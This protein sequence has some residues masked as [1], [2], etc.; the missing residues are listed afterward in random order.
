MKRA[1]G[2]QNRGEF[3]EI[4]KNG[5]IPLLVSYGAT[6]PPVP[7]GMTREQHEERW[8]AELK[9]TRP[10][11]YQ[12]DH[13]EDANYEWSARYGAKLAHE[14]QYQDIVHQGPEKGETVEEFG[15]KMKRCF[16]IMGR[17]EEEE[18][19]KKFYR[20]DMDWEQSVKPTAVSFLVPQNMPDALSEFYMVNLMMMQS[21]LEDVMMQLPG[22]RVA[23]KRG[24]LVLPEDELDMW[25]D[26]NREIYSPPRVEGMDPK[27]VSLYES[28][29]WAERKDRAV[30]EGTK[31]T[32]QFYNTFQ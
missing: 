24:E 7:V 19:R 27:D 4:K 23:N 25:E 21:H 31:T 14:Q 18:L 10:E 29:W 30:D 17:G 11:W 3:N 8:L 6:M 20:E 9:K 2:E 13:G 1:L 22:Q 32:R 15:E 5:R 26:G 12:G 16:V 28:Q